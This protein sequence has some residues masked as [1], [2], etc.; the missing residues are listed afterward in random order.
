MIAVDT[1]ILVYAHREDSPFHDAAYRRLASLAEG[2]AS[3]AIPWPCLHEFLAI[4]THP[5][6]Y[7]PPTPLST[8]LAQVDAWIESPSLVLLAESTSHWL[9]LRNL[10]TTGRIAGPMVHDA[11]VAALCRQH[12]VRELWSADRDFGRF[13][14]L[15]VKNPLVG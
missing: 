8:A 7:A 14:G 3:W 12:G 15:L 4:V 2:A 10:L 9:T 5:R 11:R 1:N 6:I 13:S